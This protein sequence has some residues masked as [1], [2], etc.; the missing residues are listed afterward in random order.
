MDGKPLIPRFEVN[1]SVGDAA[2]GRPVADGTPFRML[3]IGDFSGRGCR[4]IDESEALSQRK[5]IAVDRD[6]FDEVFKRLTPSLSLRLGSDD[7]EPTTITFNELDD[8]HPDRLFDRID[9]FAQLRQLRR[10]LNNKDLFAEA[11]AELTAGRVEAV[12][13]PVPEAPPAPATPPPEV[14]T[15]NLLD[16]AL[17]ATDPSSAAS[18]ANPF[19]RVI[20][21]IIAPYIEPAA[22][23]RQPEFVAAVDNAVGEQMRRLLHHPEFQQLELTWRGLYLLVRRLETGRKLKL[24]LLD[25]SQQELQRDLTNREDLGESGLWKLLSDQSIGTPGN[26]PFGCLIGCYEVA[27]TVDAITTAA[28]MA[29]IARQL[30]APLLVGVHSRFAGCDSFGHSPDPADW[31]SPLEETAAELWREFRNDPAAE[32]LC[33]LA[34]R[35]LARLPYGT[36]TDAVESFDFEEFAETPTHDHYLWGPSSFLGALSL[37]IGFTEVGWNLQVG[38]SR[39]FDGMPM[40]VFQQ[41]GESEQKPCAEAWLTERSGQAMTDAGL[42]PVFSIRNRDAV[43]LPGLR[44]ASNASSEL[45]GGWR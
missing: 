3:V 40:H 34:P 20:Q 19:D 39:E 43:L 16:A 21:E 26:D 29:R 38:R 24:Q 25:V 45:A 31:S 15:E 30:N 14:S 9:L 13:A 8:F 42:S 10:R 2:T 32:F 28:G 36:K 22:D 7:A 12:S 5:L 23:P 11:A 37:G 17:E 35:F 44:S 4:E 18:T 6:D 33:G 41:D 27:P 1:L